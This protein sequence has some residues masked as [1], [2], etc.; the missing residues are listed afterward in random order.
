MKL[1]SAGLFAVVF[2]VT[3]IGCN[4]VHGPMSLGPESG[5]GLTEVNVN[6][7]KIP[8]DKKALMNAFSLSIKPQDPTACTNPT[9]FTEVR[10]WA[11]GKLQDLKVQQGCSYI[12][13]LDLGGRDA[14]NQFVAYFTNHPDA[15]LGYILPKED[16][17]GKAKLEKPLRIV[18]HIT[19]AGTQAGLGSLGD[20]IVTETQTDFDI[21]VQFQT[22]GGNPLVGQ[23]LVPC[24]ADASV[25]VKKGIQL[26][27]AGELATYYRVFADAA[28]TQMLEERVAK[29]TYKDA[30]AAP[31]AAELR[32][33]DVTFTEIKY[34]LG[35]EA[36]ATQLNAN[37][38]EG[39]GLTNWKAA[40]V[41]DILADP[42]AS[43]A[44]KARVGDLALFDLLSLKQ[45]KLL[46]G[47]KA[48]VDAGLAVDKRPA[49]V[50][51]APLSTY[52][53]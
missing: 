35:T 25:Y 41:R 23:W 47:E 33:L 49:T 46:L 7:P 27:A 5:S 36:R 44:C 30:G 24:T 31:N 40:E 20:A 38:A 50:R 37:A 28:C 1:S 4:R 3:T 19:P 11:D 13:Q 18:V 6:L 14:Q 51:E 15:E 21:D 42:A 52:A 29:G 8:D 34:Q 48:A 32:L 45:G 12:I 10:A 53:K 22:G 26:G 9:N 16:I 43:A 17:A 39:C 2:G